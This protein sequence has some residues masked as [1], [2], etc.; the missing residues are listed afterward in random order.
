MRK[1]NSMASTLVKPKRVTTKVIKTIIISHSNTKLGKIPSF[2]LPAIT[3]CPGRTT[4]CSNKCYADKIARIYKNAA[5]SYEINF[6]ATRSNKDFVLLMNSELNILSKK[7]CNTFRFHVS[8]DFYDVAYIHD[9]INIVKS[10]PAIMFYGYTRT[11]SIPNMLP[12]L[13]A[14][15]CLPNVI[16]FASTD[17]STFGNAPIGWREAYAGNAKLN[18][19][20]MITCLEQAGKVPTCDKCRLCFNFK[21]TLNIHFK[22]H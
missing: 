15:R 9:W 6:N 21:S 7:G 14:L 19:K 1:N 13:E 4:W 5:K 3:S 20:K 2:S 12:H 18:G 17:S 22:P 8:G 11:W 10:N 16:L